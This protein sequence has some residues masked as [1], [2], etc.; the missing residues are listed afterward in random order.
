MELN[1]GQKTE[2]R[3]AQPLHR[4]PSVPSISG[5]AVPR[6]RNNGGQEC[7]WP[8]HGLPISPARAH[9]E[10]RGHVQ[11]R[12]GGATRRASPL[13]LVWPCSL[14]PVR[15]IDH[16]KSHNVTLG[17]IRYV[18]L[19]SFVTQKPTAPHVVPRQVSLHQNYLGKH[20]AEKT[21]DVLVS[22]CRSKTR[23][24]R[25]VGGVYTRQ[26]RSVGLTRM[27]GRKL[28]EA[29]NPDDGLL[30]SLALNHWLNRWNLGTSLS[31]TA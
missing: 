23:L 4:G 2:S 12:A 18:A 31:V 25:L 28:C 29:T 19:L 20:A 1:R 17:S 26:H 15:L 16:H 3:N 24:I 22:I 6:S 13:A 21:I 7:C 8:K 11:A 30:T 9:A 5:T 14:K 10:E 27:P